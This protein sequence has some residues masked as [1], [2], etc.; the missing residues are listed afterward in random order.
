MSNPRRPERGHISE[1]HV[2]LGRALRRCREDLGL[3]T[4]QIPRGTVSGKYFMS[5]H[6]SNVENGHTAPSEELVETYIELGGDGTLLRSLYRQ[7][8]ASSDEL[9]RGRRRVGEPASQ[10]LPPQDARQVADHNDVQKH[11]FVEAN[12]AHCIFD[13]RGVITE[14]RCVATIRART[15]GVRLYYTGHT[16]SS[17][18]RPGVLRAEATSGGTVSQIREGPTGALQAYFDLERSLSPRDKDPHVLTFRILVTSDAPARPILVF[19]N[20]RGGACDMRLRAQFGAPM[21]PTR[22]WRFA[23]EDTIDAEHPSPGGEFT[24]NEEGLYAYAFEGLTP[25]W[26]YG[27][28]WAW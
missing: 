18:R 12:E 17:D 8:R 11:Y 4:R 24:L 21:M 19:H 2:R 22:I 13:G 16:Y 28:A 5:G 7:M 23:V 1:A 15:D 20:S 10:V 9:G 6:I 3:N 27:F 26:S 25:Q 14:F